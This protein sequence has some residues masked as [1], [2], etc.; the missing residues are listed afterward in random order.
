MAYRIPAPQLFL[1]AL[2]STQATFLRS[3]FPRQKKRREYQFHEARGLERILEN[4]I[5]QRNA[6]EDIE[7]RRLVV[8]ERKK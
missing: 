7:K 3:S 6:D 8:G 1:S 2:S 4:I 5:S